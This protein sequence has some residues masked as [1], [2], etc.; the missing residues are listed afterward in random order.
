MQKITDSRTFW[1]TIESFLSSKIVSTEKVT[2]ID[3]SETVQTEVDTAHVLNNVFL[4]Q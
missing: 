3:N 1:K 4:L 2:L